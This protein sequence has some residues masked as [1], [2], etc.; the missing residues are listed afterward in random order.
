MWMVS[1][2]GKSEKIKLGKK[3]KLSNP[4]CCPGSDCNPVSEARFSIEIKG[5]ES[6]L[7]INEL[8]VVLLEKTI[9]SVI[10]KRS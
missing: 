10:A 1:C 8:A 7:P 4:F 6:R 3:C 5:A 2:N 9:E